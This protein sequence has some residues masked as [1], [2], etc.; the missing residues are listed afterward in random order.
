MNALLA[1]E[2]QAKREASPPP[3]VNRS[4][5]LINLDEAIANVGAMKLEKGSALDRLIFKRVFKHEPKEGQNTLEELEKIGTFLGKL[6]AE[7]FPRLRKA[8]DANPDM[9]I[10]GKL[11]TPEELIARTAPNTYNEVNLLTA[12]A[13]AV[14][15]EVPHFNGVVLEEYML[16][17]GKVPANVEPVLQQAVA[18]QMPLYLLRAQKK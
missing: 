10:F 13:K 3:A 16:E 4:E 9:T 18:L 2:I 5:L 8:N 12:T 1:A 17:D 6:C 11:L 14:G 7:N 15:L